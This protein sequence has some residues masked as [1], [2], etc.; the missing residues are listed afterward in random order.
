MAVNLPDLD[1]DLD[2]DVAAARAATPGCADRNFLLSAGSSLPTQ[3]TLD[4]VVGHLRREA[5]V[6]GIGAPGA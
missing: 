6:G 4:A 1:R 5:A 3:T 2:L